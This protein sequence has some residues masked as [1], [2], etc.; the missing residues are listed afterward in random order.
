MIIIRFLFEM[1]MYYDEILVLIK[2]DEESD[3]DLE[4][5]WWIIG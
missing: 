2:L 1:W 3:S 5:Y 4:V